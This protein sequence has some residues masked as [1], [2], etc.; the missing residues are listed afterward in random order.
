MRSKPDQHLVRLPREKFTTRKGLLPQKWD[1]RDRLGI[2]TKHFGMNLKQQ[3]RRQF[4]YTI[5]KRKS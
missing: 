2:G 5:F 1:S 3:K 4:I